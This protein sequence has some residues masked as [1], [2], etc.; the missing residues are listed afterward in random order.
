MTAEH[1]KPALVGQ[2]T[3]HETFKG[4]C[5]NITQILSNI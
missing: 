3:I 5:V 1:R 2:T 4:C